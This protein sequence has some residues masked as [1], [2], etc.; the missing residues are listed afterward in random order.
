M[1][2][3][4]RV[5]EARPRLTIVIPAFNEAAYVGATLD[6]VQAAAQRL[7]TRSKVDVET[8]VVDN[9]S[10]DGTAA[11]ARSRSA[12]VVHEPVQ[13]IARARNTGA[14]HARGEV[15]L[16]VDADVFVPPSLLC[17]V[18]V[19]MSDP[20]CI[21]GGADVEY[22]P[23]R[24]FVSLYL[25]AWRVLGTLTGMVQGAA[26]FCRKGVHEHLGGYDETAWIGEDVDFYWSLQRLARESG[27]TVRLIREPRVRPS[28]RRFDMWPLWKIV[29][30]TNPL[31]IALFRRWKAVWKGWYTDPVR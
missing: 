20:Q 31:F 19:A 25:H 14:R 9:N 28:C 3:A 13:G 10:N 26:Q 22:R 27:R 17:A 16:F 8:I 30:W 7:R 4:D 29:V 23:R 6:S 18:Y 1:I 21:G 5:T 15:L 11:V 24:V 12:M 2:N